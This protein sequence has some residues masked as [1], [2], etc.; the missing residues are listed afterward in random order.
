MVDMG[1]SR[2]GSRCARRTRSGDGLQFGRTPAVG[3][4]GRR[5]VT[6]GSAVLGVSD[7]SGGNQGSTT[8]VVV[9]A[10]QA[11]GRPGA[12]LVL[13]GA[14]ACVLV[15]GWWLPVSGRVVATVAALLVLVVAALVDAVEHRLPNRLVA[16][17]A[18]TAARLLG[19]EAR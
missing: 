7:A 15:G 18:L 6:L 8:G 17:A 16:L 2:A 1:R 4:G 10:W 11:V 19:L 3:A 9:A 5:G 12:S 14:V 13:A